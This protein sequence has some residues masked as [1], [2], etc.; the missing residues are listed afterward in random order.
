[1]LFDD[2][3]RLVQRAQA[4]DTQAELHR[5]AGLLHVW[6][7]LVPYLREARATVADAV[8]FLDRELA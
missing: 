7:I 1:M 8:H 4:A 5:T 3:Q 2:A 6:P